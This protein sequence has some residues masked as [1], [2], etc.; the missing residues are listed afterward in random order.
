MQILNKNGDQYIILDGIEHKV[1]TLSKEIQELV[2]MQLAIEQ[3]F[4]TQK[5]RALL[6]ISGIDA[7]IK[8]QLEGKSDE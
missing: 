1:N 5:V 4:E 6:A 7:I 8:S 2:T 3:D